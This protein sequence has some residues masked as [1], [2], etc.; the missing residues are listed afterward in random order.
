MIT[1]YI[2]VLL[3]LNIYINYLLLKTTS[4]ITHTRTRFSRIMTASA[5]G[6]LYSLLILFPQ[7]G[8]IT[9]IIIKYIAAVTI[10]AI[11]FEIVTIKRLIINSTIFF[12]VNF[13]FAG[14]V[15]AVFS[16]LGSDT[17]HINNSYIYIDFSLIV[18]LVTTS[19]LYYLVCII[20]YIYDKQPDIDGRYNVFIRYKGKS[21][22]LEGLA[23]TGNSLVDFFTGY[24]VIVCDKN[25][26]NSI[27]GDVCSENYGTAPPNGF[28][29]IPCS[30]IVKEGVIPVFRPDEVIISD[31]DKGK[32]KQVE[33]LIGITSE[34]SKAIFN[35]KLMKL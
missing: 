15:Y 20:R 5:Y 22:V 31:N 16:F 35:P 10:V 26:I 21:A 1:I 33:A 30:T 32:R 14:A 13:C 3:I 23:D 29:F 34:C 25:T 7:I 28:R 2:D 17:I 18:L 8:T 6:S 27:T 11:A 9:N 12:A 19:V 24:P 4:K